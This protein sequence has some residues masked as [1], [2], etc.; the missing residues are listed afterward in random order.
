MPPKEFFRRLAPGRQNCFMRDRAQTG[1]AQ[2]RSD[3]EHLALELSDISLRARSG[4]SIVPAGSSKSFPIHVMGVVNG[5]KQLIVTAPATPEGGLIAVYKGQTLNCH[6]VNAASTFKFATHIIK[7]VF[8]PIPLLYLEIDSAVQRH[9]LRTLPRALVALRA[10]IKTPKVS[11]AL[12]TDLSV[13][14]SRIAVDEDVQLQKSQEL[15]LIAKPQMLDKEYL[16]TLSCSVTG[17][18]EVSRPKSHNVRYYG[19]R[20]DNPSEQEM[21]VVHAYVQ[22]SLAVEAD[23]LTQLLQ[24]IYGANSGVTAA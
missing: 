14:G 20:F 5:H 11:N 16:V 4:L 18:L 24:R 23:A 15:E 9:A 8:E 21:L 19:L 10:I 13:G 17:E 6:W 7:V 22:Q 3:L 1:A 12:I 2:Q